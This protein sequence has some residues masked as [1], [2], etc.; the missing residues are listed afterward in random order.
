MLFGQGRL[1]AT[2]VLVF[3][4]LVTAVSITPAIA[5]ISPWALQA[6]AEIPTSPKQGYDLY[7][8]AKSLE[9]EY[10]RFVARVKSTPNWENSSDGYQ[11]K[12]RW[13]PVFE[14]YRDACDA[15]YGLGC[16]DMA[17]LNPQ[18]KDI[19]LPRACA[20]G[21]RPA[22]RTPSEIAG[23]AAREDE[24]AGIFRG[25]GSPA[26]SE[27]LRLQKLCDKSQWDQC[28]GF[29]RLAAARLLKNCELGNRDSCIEYAEK[30]RSY[31]LR[32][33]MPIWESPRASPAMNRLCES[34]KSGNDYETYCGLATRMAAEAA[35]Q[36]QPAT[37]AGTTL[38]QRQ[39]CINEGRGEIIDTYREKTGTLAVD[40]SGE[41]VEATRLVTVYAKVY[42]NICR[43]PVT[44]TCVTGNRPVTLTLGG[45]KSTKYCN[46]FEAL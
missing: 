10:N 11:I 37:A 6:S 32:E 1:F 28:P 39:K 8:K 2:L 31:N 21:Y 16:V 14:A 17:R 7:L 24:L 20:T 38:A 46:D 13:T 18:L 27:E 22:C 45:R 34:W 42:T 44:G 4:G 12:A 30:A 9:A 3:V 35:Y 41:T 23:F 36:A 25:P 15:G 19:F 40:S 29:V 5:K 33:L 43:F 26:T